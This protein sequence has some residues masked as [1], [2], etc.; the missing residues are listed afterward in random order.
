MDYA[1]IEKGINELGVK[2]LISL[3]SYT[4]LGYAYGVVLLVVWIGNGRQSTR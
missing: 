3:D 4:S 1:E 2:V